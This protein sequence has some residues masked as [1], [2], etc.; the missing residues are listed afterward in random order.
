MGFKEREQTHRGTWCV[1]WRGDSEEPN[2]PWARHAWTTRETE[3]SARAWCVLLRRRA[4]PSS[5]SSYDP[6]DMSLTNIPANRDAGRRAHRRTRRKPTR[7]LRCAVCRRFGVQHTPLSEPVIQQCLTCCGGI[8]LFCAHAASASSCAPES[9]ISSLCAS[10]LHEAPRKAS[11]WRNVWP[12]PK[13]GPRRRGSPCTSSR[14]V[15]CPRDP[16]RPRGE[17]RPFTEWQRSL[18]SGSA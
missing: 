1:S 11:P 2:R 16:E 3:V 12:Y 14:R 8:G 7:L 9:V 6:A 17:Q 5:L 10:C 15:R 13:T 4:H 18:R